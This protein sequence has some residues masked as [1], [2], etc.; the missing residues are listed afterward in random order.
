MCCTV[1]YCTVLYCTVLLY[2]GKGCTDSDTDPRASLHSPSYPTPQGH[3]GKQKKS[4]FKYQ[5]FTFALQN[6][7]CSSFPL[8]GPF[9]FWFNLVLNY[10]SWTRNLVGAIVGSLEEYLPCF[11]FLLLRENCFD[12]H[13]LSYKRS[14]IFF[15]W[16]SH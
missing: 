13:I 9:C 16:S 15:C 5:Q 3:T 14:T 4:F 7:F 11:V 2:L 1:L 10:I 6:I 8:H 12:I